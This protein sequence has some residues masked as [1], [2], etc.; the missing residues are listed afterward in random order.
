LSTVS[1]AETLLVYVVAPLALVVVLALLTL[2]PDR[3][4]HRA[5]Y[6]PGRPWEHEPVWYAP[7]PES[8]PATGHGQAPA[9]EARDAGQARTGGPL[10]GARGTW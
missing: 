3:S 9:L 8:M 2:R 6:R 1:I 10:G 4:T 7:H 5:R